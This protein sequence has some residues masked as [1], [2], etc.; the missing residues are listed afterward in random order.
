MPKSGFQNKKVQNKAMQMENLAV[1]FNV[2]ESKM[3]L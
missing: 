3:N 1:N 2:K